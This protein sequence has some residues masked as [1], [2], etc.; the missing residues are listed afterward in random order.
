[1]FTSK[2]DGDDFSILTFSV[3]DALKVEVA[4]LLTAY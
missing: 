1:M 2:L 3:A 4:C